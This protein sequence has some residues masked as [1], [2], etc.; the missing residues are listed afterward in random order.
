MCKKTSV[1]WVHRNILQ[2]FSTTAQRSFL[3][4]ASFSLILILNL[5]SVYTQQAVICMDTGEYL[6]PK[7]IF[8]WT[9]IF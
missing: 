5:K 8:F 1:L 9:Y 3:C 4:C 6:L 2:F 7:Y